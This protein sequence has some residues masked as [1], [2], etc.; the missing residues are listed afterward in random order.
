MHWNSDQ[1]GVSNLFL[2]G[3]PVSC[4]WPNCTHPSGWYCYSPNMGGL[5]ARRLLW[6]LLALALLLLAASQSLQSFQIALGAHPSWGR[7]EEA[8]PYLPMMDCGYLLWIW[9]YALWLGS[10]IWS[11]GV[12]FF[13]LLSRMGR[14]VCLLG[15]TSPFLDQVQ[16]CSTGGS[17][18]L[19]LH[20]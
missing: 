20:H 14:R 11:G 8:G 15:H 9:G 18:A 5:M 7:Y 2:A 3:S 12:F 4:L 10:L 6:R 1:L 13:K 19:A 17:W 16:V